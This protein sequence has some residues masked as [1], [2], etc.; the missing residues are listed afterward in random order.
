[1]R[2]VL[3]ILAVLGGTV[4][5]GSAHAQA[6]DAIGTLFGDTFFAEERIT[7]SVRERPDVS[8]LERSEMNALLQARQTLSD[9]FQA[10]KPGAKADVL[11]F[12]APE[13][14]GRYVDRAALRRERFGAEAYLSFEIIDFRISEDRSEIKLRY[15][16][17][18]N[19][20]GKALIR[21]RAVT[22]RDGGSGLRIAEFDNFSFD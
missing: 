21:Q 12:L 20:Q 18:E 16:L 13:L 8:Y 4:L 2:K 3:W 19:N 14:A 11:A 22:F 15:F 10:L 17:A 7:E 5:P 6:Q 1:M 9:F